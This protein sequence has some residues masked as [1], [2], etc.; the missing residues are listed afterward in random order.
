M[1]PW[2]WNGLVLYVETQVRGEAMVGTNREG[3]GSLA[4]RSILKRLRNKVQEVGKRWYFGGA[5][6]LRHLF[7]CA[8][9]VAFTE[10]IG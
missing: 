2:P 5:T 7:H 8:F 10:M 6:L 1:V 9:V 4:G 3:H